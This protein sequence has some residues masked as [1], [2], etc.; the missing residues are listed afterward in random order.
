MFR[1]KNVSTCPQYGKMEANTD[2]LLGVS[3]TGSDYIP[4]FIQKYLVNTYYGP[5]S[6]LESRNDKTR[7]EIS[8]PSHIYSP[9]GKKR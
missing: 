2:L 1:A 3:G 9:S 6:P 5:D 4:A 8:L 7:Q